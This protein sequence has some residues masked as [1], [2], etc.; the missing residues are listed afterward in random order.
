MPVKEKIK[1]D[2]ISFWPGFNKTD[3]YFYNLLSEHYQIEIADNP[4]YIFYS[5][6]DGGNPAFN[7]YKCFRIFYTGENRRPN[8]N[9]CDYA[10]T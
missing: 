9:E 3:N 5:I 2:F 4:D 6:F 8:S 7:Q 1:I 10:F